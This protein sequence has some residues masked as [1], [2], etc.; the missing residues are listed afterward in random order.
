M[1]LKLSQ[2]IRAFRRRIGPARL[3]EWFSQM[4]TEVSQLDDQVLCE[5]PAV[6]ASVSLPAARIANADRLRIL[7]AIGIVW[8]HIEI[9]PHRNIAYAGLPIFLLIFCSLLTS[10]GCI[11][12]TTDFLVRRWRRLLKP[13]LFWSA[14]YGL[15]RLAM[16]LAATDG[17]S[18]RNMISA[19]TLLAGTS[20]H[21]WYLPYA[22]LCGVAIHKLNG[23]TSGIHDVIVLLGAASL[24]MVLLA[25]HATGTWSHLV[26]PLPQ[27]EF[28]LTAI[29]LGIGV[30][31]CLML[32]SR[33]R[34]R[35][36]LLMIALMVAI[37]CLI[38]QHLGFGSPVV[39][40][41]IGLVLVCL[42]YCWDI[43]SDMIV[44]SL[45]PLTFGIYLIHPLIIPVLRRVPTME[46]HYVVLVLLTVCVSAL[47]T[48]VLMSTPLRRFV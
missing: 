21:L 36:F 9:I 43:R 29:P 11:V 16:G 22:F 3:S 8:F 31:K 45:A 35:L 6:C 4:R 18:L 25:V 17:G 19:E 27:W 38:L 47:A 34:Q 7:A 12:T 42:A 1:N 26:S 40:Y 5:A 30:G 28:G 24:G 48:L 37:E 2:P 32:S 20:I 15:C 33:Y 10:Q 41:I 13:W 14:V 46:D 44:A 39:P 23:W